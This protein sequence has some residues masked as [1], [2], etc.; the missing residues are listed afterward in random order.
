MA[1]EFPDPQH[2][3]PQ[4]RRPVVH[5]V[6]AE[7]AVAEGRVALAEADDEAQDVLQGVRRVAAPVGPAGPRQRVEL[8]Q[9]LDEAAAE[10][11]EGDEIDDGLPAPRGLPR[12][13]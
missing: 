4:G 11:A 2:E 10:L 9:G 8:E 6:V 13:A 5:G 7:E 3:V 1:R 12:R